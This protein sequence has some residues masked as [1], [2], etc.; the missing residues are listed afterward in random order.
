MLYIW[1][2][3]KTLYTDHCVSGVVD[4]PKMEF[5]SNAATSTFEIKKDG[6]YLETRI[7]TITISKIAH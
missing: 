6:E 3:Y 7:V 2:V 5:D 1:F 4:K